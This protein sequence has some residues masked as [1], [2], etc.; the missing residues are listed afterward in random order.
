MNDTRWM[1]ADRG[2]PHAALLPLTNDLGKIGDRLDQMSTRFNTN[3]AIAMGWAG[4]PS[5]RAPM[6]IA[7]IG[8]LIVSTIMSLFIVPVV[9]TVVDDFQQWLGRIWRRGAPGDEH[10]GTMPAPSAIG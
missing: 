3:H 8:G 5:F 2:C 10:E 1:V 7:V 9:F 4:D 6:G